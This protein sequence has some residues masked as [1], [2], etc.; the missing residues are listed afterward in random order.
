[1]YVAGVGVFGSF[2]FSMD[3]KV[4]F[5]PPTESGES[6]ELGRRDGAE[7]GSS[8]VEFESK[9]RQPNFLPHGPYWQMAYFGFCGF[10]FWGVLMIQI[11]FMDKYFGGH[12]V[13]FYITFAFTLSSNLIRVVLIWLRGRPSSAKHTL[14]QQ[15]GVLVQYGSILSA[16]TMFSFP[17]SMAI[18]G[19]NHP[20]IGFWI[21][22][23]LCTLMGLFNSL[24]INV[25]FG[26]MSMAPARS[27]AAFLIGQTSAG[28]VGWPVIILFRKIV[29]ACGGGEAADMIVAVVTLCLCGILT[30]AQIPLYRFRTQFHPV[31]FLQLSKIPEK[32][33]SDSNAL[34]GVMGKIFVPAM[35]GW[36][37]SLVSFSVFPIQIGR[38]FP[39]SQIDTSVYRS[40]LIYMFAVA[41]A[42]GRAS[43][44]WAPASLSTRVFVWA[45]LVRGIVFVPL[46][47]LCAHNFE[48]LFGFDWWRLVL[49]LGLG[50]TN[51]A[52]FGLANMLAPRLVSAS[53]K[54][55]TGTILAFLAVNGRFVG[56]LIGIG[57]KEV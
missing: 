3:G 15:L 53:E 25:G 49:V 17:I 20:T 22:I 54:M 28:V 50:I 12:S 47:I 18:L 44:R 37:T 11:P 5:G 42:A 24:L 34:L 33:G 45:T 26:L 23:L 55:L 6:V 32:G 36:F 29:H 10:L 38:W 14:G 52:N 8:M 27:A 48:E 43:L 7:F 46:I 56:A 1:M 51:G 9:V 19:Q 16:V 30:L 39:H 41:D 21:C 13:I 2:F 57:L 31:F 4:Q 35:C 40:F